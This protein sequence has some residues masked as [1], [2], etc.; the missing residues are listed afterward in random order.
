[1]SN[2]LD[3]IKNN[4]DMIQENET[5]TEVIASLAGYQVTKG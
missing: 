5:D 1:M 4:M 3:N 2:Q